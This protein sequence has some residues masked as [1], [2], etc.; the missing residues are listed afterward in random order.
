MPPTLQGKNPN[1]NANSHVQL[2]QIRRIRNKNP[3]C[4][5]NSNSVFYQPH[6]NNVKYDDTFHK[7]EDVL[8]KVFFKECAREEERRGMNGVGPNS[9]FPHAGGIGQPTA[10]GNAGAQIM[11]PNKNDP[12]THLRIIDHILSEFMFVKEQIDR[13]KPLTSAQSL[14]LELELERV[15]SAH[16]AFLLALIRSGKINTENL[17]KVLAEVKQSGSAIDTECIYCKYS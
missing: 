17:L 14:L 6:Y 8:R 10:M 12:H 3:N 7:K 16:K 2:S 1:Q 15:H 9:Q 4:N 13:S 11:K 5:H